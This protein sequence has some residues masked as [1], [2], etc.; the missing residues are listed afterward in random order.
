[1]RYFAVLRDQFI[2]NAID[3]KIKN[4]PLRSETMAMVIFAHYVTPGKIFIE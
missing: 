2:N 4:K 3:C 1:M